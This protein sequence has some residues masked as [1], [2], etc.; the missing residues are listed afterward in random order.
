[1]PPP[2]RCG[3]QQAAVI[4]AQIKRRI[5]RLG[6]GGFEGALKRRVT[7]SGAG[8]VWLRLRT[9]L[10]PM[11]S[12]QGRICK[13][14]RRIPPRVSAR[15]RLGVRRRDAASATSPAN[16]PIVPARCLVR[17][18]RCDGPI[19]PRR[20]AAA[21]SGVGRAI[22]HVIV[23]FGDAP[24]RVARLWASRFSFVPS[25]HLWSS[26]STGRVCSASARARP[27]P[28]SS[29]PECYQ[30]RQA[31]AM[32]VELRSVSYRNEHLRSDVHRTNGRHPPSKRTPQEACEA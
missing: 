27:S 30:P 20:F 28:V 22:L 6:T 25:T 8:N 31:S 4:G 19:D 11:R 12:V 9:G 32:R 21:P 15:R 24:V 18:E 7:F 1:M 3:D 29:C 26:P 23:P 16:G 14:Q 10:M 2:G 17:L 5:G 13:A